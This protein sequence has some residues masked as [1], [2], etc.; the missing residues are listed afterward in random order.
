MSW[1]R[2]SDEFRR[3]VGMW[4]MVRKKSF[5]EKI[6]GLFSFISAHND[7]F[8]LC[9]GLNPVKNTVNLIGFFLREDLGKRQRLKP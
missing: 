1:D 7:I 2:Y 3:T 9:Y 4:L 8:A 6:K 5:H